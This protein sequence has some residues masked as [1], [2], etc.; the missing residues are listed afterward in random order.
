MCI[1]IPGRVVALDPLHSQHAWAEVCGAR[2]EINI[3]LVCQAGQPREALLGSW[4]LIH[5]GFALSRLD[6]RKPLRCW[7]RYRRWAKWKTTWR[8][9]WRGKAMM[10]YVDEFR[11]PQ[12]VKSLLQRIAQ[13]AAKLPFSAERPLQLMEV[14]G[15]HTHAI[16]RFGLDKLLPPQVEFIHGQVARCAYCRWGVSTP[17]MKSPPTPR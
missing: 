1:G 7:R 15:G 16:F 9:L 5:V 3:A 17:A 11:D 2:R 12:L 14:C 13:R 8:C 4:V 10:K 6:E